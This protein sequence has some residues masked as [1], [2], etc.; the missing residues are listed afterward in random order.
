MRSNDLWCTLREVASRCQR[1]M[2]QARCNLLR[3]LASGQMECQ[4]ARAAA[5]PEDDDGEGRRLIGLTYHVRAVRPMANA[6]SS[7]KLLLRAIASPTPLILNVQRRTD[8]SG[9]ELCLPL[10]SAAGRPCG[11]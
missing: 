5:P 2:I 3:M 10:T 6:F 11:T 1:H 8:R 9:V 4:L 7:T